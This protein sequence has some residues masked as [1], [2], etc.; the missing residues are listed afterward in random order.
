MKNAS[1]FLFCV[2]PRIFRATK[3]PWPSLLAYFPSS[4]VLIFPLLSPSPLAPSQEIPAPAGPPRTGPPVRPAP[5]PPR[6]PAPRPAR[7][8]A[9]PGL[10]LRSQLRLPGTTKT[11]SSILCPQ[12][13]R[14]WSLASLGER[15][16]FWRRL[17]RGWDVDLGRRPRATPLDGPAC[18]GCTGSPGWPWSQPGPAPRGQPGMGGRPLRSGGRKS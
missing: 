6:P 12:C 16:Q 3:P 17:R 4:P 5:A 10:C 9:L 1:L 11:D 8:A 7:S 18:T 15:V 2:A 14:A 13:S